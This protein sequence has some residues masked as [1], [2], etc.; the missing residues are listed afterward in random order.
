MIT[1][2]QPLTTRG[3]E[4]LRNYYADERIRIQTVRSRLLASSKGGGVPL[5]FPAAPTHMVA[6]P[7]LS[8]RV[9]GRPLKSTGPRRARDD[10]R[11]GE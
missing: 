4:T 1:A 6:A 5:I 9:M 11:D 10:F 3:K 2:Q 7:A 8:L